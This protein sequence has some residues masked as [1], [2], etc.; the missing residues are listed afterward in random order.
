MAIGYFFLLLV[1]KKG[2]KKK[3]REKTEQVRTGPQMFQKTKHMQS[4][5]FFRTIQ[6][7][8]AIQRMKSCAIPQCLEH[9][10]A[11]VSDL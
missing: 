2:Q 8:M 7:T 6:M 5:L 9:L 4:P 3:L 1:G 10:W 11:I